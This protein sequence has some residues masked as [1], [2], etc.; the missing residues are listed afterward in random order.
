LAK[1]ANSLKTST[2]VCPSCASKKIIF[3]DNKVFKC[4]DCDFLYFHNVAAANGCLISVPPSD[5]SDVERLVFLVRG[6]EPGI[7]KLDLPGGFADPGEGILD[8]L[9]R[10]LKEELGWAPPIP[11]GKTLVDVFK[12]FASFANLYPYRGINYNTCDMYFTISAPGLTPECLKLEE[13]EVTGVCFLKP[14][15]LNLEEIAFEPIKRAM[16]LYLKK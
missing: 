2:R 6:R 3:E 11:E 1:E 14:D 8:G 13:D 5:P 4:P 7:G 12:L 9:Y 16:K 10:E 15:E